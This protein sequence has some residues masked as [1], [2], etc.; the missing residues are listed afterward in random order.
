MGDVLL[1]CLRDAEPFPQRLRDPPRDRLLLPR[2]DDLFYLHFY[3]SPILQRLPTLRRRQ[4]FIIDPLILR[5][6]VWAAAANCA[7]SSSCSNIRR[8][9][10]WKAVK[11]MAVTLPF[12][13]AATT[14]Y[15]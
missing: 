10:F 2:L 6:G 1:P 7:I 5:H 11:S 4:P 14:L 3:F 9:W 15:S 12:F 8:L 13:T